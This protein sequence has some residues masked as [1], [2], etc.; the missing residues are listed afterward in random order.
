MAEV[1]AVIASVLTIL[2][3]TAEGVNRINELYK[4]PAEIKSLQEQLQAFL[5]VVES[6]DATVNGSTQKTLHSS[7]SRARNVIEELH[8]LITIKLVRQGNG[9]GRVRRSA[10]LRNRRNI[11]RLHDK[12]KDVREALLG[13]ICTD[14]LASTCRVESN[15]NTVSAEN[16]LNQWQ[17]SPN[18]RMAMRMIRKTSEDTLESVEE[19]FCTLAP[20]MGTFGHLLRKSS[21]SD[22][23]RLSEDSTRALKSPPLQ[24]QP[25]Y[26]KSIQ[27]ALPVSAFER[28]PSFR[29]ET[30]TDWDGTMEAPHGIHDDEHRVEALESG[31]IGYVDPRSSY[32]VTTKLIGGLLKILLSFQDI[33]QDSHLSIFLGNQTVFDGGAKA[34]SLPVK[35]IKAPFQAKTYLQSITSMVKH[36]NCPCYHERSLVRRPLYVKNNFI[37]YLESGW[38]FEQRFGSEKSQIDSD[39]YVL[40]VLQCLQ[41]APGISPFVGVVLDEKSGI[42]S[43]FLRELPAKGKLSRILLHAKKA[44]QPVPWARREKWCRQIVRG[45]AEMHS[46]GFVVGFLGDYPLCG[47]A[48]DAQDS[49]ILFHHFRTEYTYDNA[50]AGILPPEQRQSAWMRDAVVASPQS[51]IYQLGMLLWRIAAHDRYSNIW[52]A[53]K[54]ADCKIYTNSP[55]TELHTNLI[56]LPLPGEHTPQHIREVIAACRTESADERPPGWKLLEMFPPLS[57]E[58]NPL[59][60]PVA[61]EDMACPVGSSNTSA[62]GEKDLGH[63][64]QTQHMRPGS[65][66]K[67]S[68][69][70]L[71]RLE[72]CLDLYALTVVCNICGEL[73]TERYFRCNICESCDF[74][75]CYFCFSRGLHCPESDHYLYEHFE[76][77]KEEQFHSSVQPTGRREVITL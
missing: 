52:N 77:Q 44:G 27:R 49:A 64:S 45:V 50:K 28:L 1:V 22:L 14:L 56:E 33:E 24:A 71:T 61:M 43:A 55:C 32:K 18:T 51:D 31:E 34:P 58:E 26:E 69:S 68:T 46:K 4:A 36:M 11:V 8:Q 13:A 70:R 40:Q 25:L 30:Y 19:P 10:W 35:F 42:I 12:L 67:C 59:A 57:E 5:D 38:V 53:C 60:A 63:T 3:A 37:T 39:L 62:V 15:L 73:T 47:I 2:R 74:D 66:G 23:L 41:G 20:P 48:I 72:E 6:V 16:S 75:L 17:S 21:Y 7:L 54:N 76:N 29:P 65:P 9:S